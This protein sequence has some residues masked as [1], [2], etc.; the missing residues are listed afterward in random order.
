MPLLRRVAKAGWSGLKPSEQKERM[1]DQLA[2]LIEWYSSSLQSGGYPLI[3]LRM[4]IES[5]V[6]PVPSEFVIPPAAHLAFTQGK[7]SLP[8]IVIAGALGSWLGATAMYWVS[9]VA[10]RPLVLAYGKFV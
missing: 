9:R 4:A 1:H 2:R 10:G 3:V 7:M 5:S 8:G 6:V